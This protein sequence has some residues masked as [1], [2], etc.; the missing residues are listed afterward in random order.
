MPSG[1][2]EGEKEEGREVEEEATGD[3]GRKF[4]FL[5]HAFLNMLLEVESTV[6]QGEVNHQLQ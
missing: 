2:K 4:F 3:R 5:P 1:K 6:L